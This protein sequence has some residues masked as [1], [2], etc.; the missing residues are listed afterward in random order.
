M[1]TYNNIIEL[2]H[3]SMMNDKCWTKNIGCELL[4][5]MTTTL[6][7]SPG[8]I[9]SSRTV[10][11]IEQLTTTASGHMTLRSPPMCSESIAVRIKS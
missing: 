1:M 7:A 4:D 9:V 11:P 3:D 6:N 2:V 5:Q 8:E 10:T